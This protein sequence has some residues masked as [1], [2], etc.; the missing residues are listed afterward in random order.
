MAK[1]TI[2]PSYQSFCRLTQNDDSKEFS[3][4]IKYEQG[5]KIQQTNIKTTLNKARII[6]QKVN[7]FYQSDPTI[8]FME[9]NIPF[10]LKLLKDQTQIKEKIDKIFQAII[11]STSKPVSFS[12][13]EMFLLTL[14]LRSIGYQEKDKNGSF[15]FTKFIG[16][17]EEAISLLSTSFHL[18]A[19]KFLSEHLIDFLKS[20]MFSKIEEEI[21]FDIIDFFIH[22]N[23]GRNQSNK[24][25]DYK[26][27]FNV[28]KD[29]NEPLFLMHFLLQIDEKSLDKDMIEYIINHV[30]GEIVTKET[31]IFIEITKKYFQ[32]K[33]TQFYN[34]RFDYTGSLQTLIIP[35][36]GNYEIEALGA[37]G[38]GG[39]TYSTIFKSK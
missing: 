12:D 29:N 36:D 39:N 37:A 35:K 38:S 20:S 33:K 7:T 17:I 2:Q 27:I 21:I 25:E 1:P 32:G 34:S 31:P 8:Q 13:E 30:D 22:Q 15:E 23:E 24:A 3:F 11:K 4:I 16:T 26:Q 14:L 9:F 18:E 19:V 5:Q 6:S 28:F 10:H